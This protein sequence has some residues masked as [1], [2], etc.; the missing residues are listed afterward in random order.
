MA[1]NR[2]SRSGQVYGPEERLTTYQAL[3]ASTINAAYQYFED[4]KK[5]SLEAGKLADLVILD[6]NPLKIPITDIK[7][8]RVIETIKEGQTVWK[9]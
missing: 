4:D 1:T 6:R 9:L 8:V 2:I 5:G 7:D 3:Q